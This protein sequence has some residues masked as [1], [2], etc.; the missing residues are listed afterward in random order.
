MPSDESARKQRRLAAERLKAAGKLEQFEARKS[1]LDVA[2]A[3]AKTK[4]S[5]SQ[6]SSSNEQPKDSKKPAVE[7]LEVSQRAK[8]QT[9]LQARI[10]GLKA[11][12]KRIQPGKEITQ[13]QL[14]SWVSD[15]INSEPVDIKID[16][17]PNRQSV[18]RLITA[19]ETPEA[20][21]D[22]WR[23]HKQLSA[24]DGPAELQRYFEEDNEKI[25]AFIG[26]VQR[27]CHDEEIDRIND[28]IERL[29]TRT[30]APPNFVKW[31]RQAAD[32]L[33]DAMKKEKILEGLEIHAKAEA[34]G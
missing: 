17:I 15:H 26:K 19:I 21:Q 24:K 8:E 1:Q 28:A 20:K 7:N 12:A 5:G 27:S 18:N 13:R 32:E 3:G 33:V 25:R 6:A 16:E 29:A 2:T 4:P 31:A 14:Y 11:I 23:T 30:R 9:A 22:F 10:E 34:K